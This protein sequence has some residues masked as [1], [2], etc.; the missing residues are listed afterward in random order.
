LNI[1]V[2]IHF[3]LDLTGHL[4]KNKMIQPWHSNL[5]S[6][7]EPY[8][9]HCRDKI[10]WYRPDIETTFGNN[11]SNPSTLLKLLLHLQ[12]KTNG[13][14]ERTPEEQ[15]YSRDHYQNIWNQV[16]A[17]KAK[18]D[19]DYANFHKFLTTMWSWEFLKN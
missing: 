10:K 1:S 15:I 2:P 3:P 4:D 19:L 8:W 17:L 6:A 7:K 18:W 11:L 12:Q 9:R 14:E 16:A 13:L 5:C